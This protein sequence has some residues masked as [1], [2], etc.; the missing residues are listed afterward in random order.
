MNNNTTPSSQGGSDRYYTAKE[1]S[2]SLRRQ[3]YGWQVEKFLDVA[4]WLAENCPDL[5]D[6]ETMDGRGV[7]MS[8]YLYDMYKAR[9]KATTGAL[10]IIEANTTEEA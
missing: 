10:P 8:C 9:G 3:D 7:E 5:W 2:D 4:E 6:S 1:V